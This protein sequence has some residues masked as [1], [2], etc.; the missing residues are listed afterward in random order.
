MDLT[1][2]LCHLQLIDLI[3]I[4]WA[5][6]MTN[7]ETRSSSSSGENNICANNSVLIKI[8]ILI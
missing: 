4:G 3:L 2:C 1:N 6:H 5:S 7:S 8:A